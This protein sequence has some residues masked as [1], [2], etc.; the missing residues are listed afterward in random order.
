[1]TIKQEVTVVDLGTTVWNSLANGSGILGD[2]FDNGNSSNLYID[3]SFELTVDFVNAPTAG[4]GIEL[5]LV[6]AVD[7]TNYA[8]STNGASEYAQANCYAGTFIVQATTAL[9]RMVLG[10]GLSGPIK[11]PG[12]KFKAFLINNSGQAFPASGSTLKMLA[13]RFQ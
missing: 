11:L 5:F 7:G 12:C 1:M 4:N 2:E 10:L 3:G 6:P 8:D 13:S 9:Q